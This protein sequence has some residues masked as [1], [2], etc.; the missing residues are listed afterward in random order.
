M[1]IYDS[2]AYALDLT[3]QPHLHD[4]SIPADVSSNSRAL[5][6]WNKN[7]RGYQEAWNKGLNKTTDLRIAKY[8]KPTP[9]KLGRTP[10]NKGTRGVAPETS[11]KMAAAKVGSI[12]WNRGKTGEKLPDVQCPHCNKIGAGNAMKQYHFD[13]C[14][15][16]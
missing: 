7:K 14:K 8:S 12:P 11:A 15:L 3:P 5:R 2:I 16:K 6:P 4:S 1:L 13:R 10:H 9:N